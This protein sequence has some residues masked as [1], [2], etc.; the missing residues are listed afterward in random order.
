MTSR[1][2]LIVDDDPDLLFLVAHGVKH[3]GE[4]YHVSTASNAVA[5][6]EKA[7]SQQFDL[8][9]TDFMMPDMTGLELITEL[10]KFSP[11]TKLIL[12]TAHHDTGQ[13]RHA[14][15][16]L[17]LAGFI[18]KPFT[19][20]ELID[21]V[22]RS[23]SD[24]EPSP[25]RKAETTSLPKTFIEEQLQSLRRQTAAN[26]VLLVDAHGAPVYAA[27]DTNRAR[28]ARLAAFVST[29]F[30]AINELATLFGDTESVFKSSYY[31]GNKYN[32]Y[33]YNVNDDYFLA[34][35]F[36]TD[37]KPGTIWFYTKQ[38]A[39]ELAATLP[40]SDATPLSSDAT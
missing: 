33:A 8:V 7:Q 15:E 2:I 22:K 27:G 31:E 3:V 1:R 25:T 38:V 36:G 14:I 5:A 10:R 17:D 28:I 21:V 23:M 16:G 30:L 6:L 26:T 24:A 34:V 4:D 32:I 19:M 11:H 29:N 37:G 39:T 13:M 12:M 20:P 18:G 9:V 40:G 35:V